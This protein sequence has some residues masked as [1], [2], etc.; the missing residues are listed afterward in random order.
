MTNPPERRTQADRVYHSIRDAILR[1]EIAE[2]ET[3]NHVA[4]AKKF[5]VSRIPVREALQ[6]L[7]AE[8][9]LVFEAYRGHR[10][11]SLGPE[12]L[13]ELIEIRILLE[14]RALRKHG[15][16]LPR[17]ELDDLLRLNEGLANQEDPELW[18]RSDWELHRRLSGGDT[19]IAELVGD[20]RRRI[21][22]YLDAASRMEDRHASAVAEHRA[23]L[24][25]L[26]RGDAR[27]A[28]KEL[29]QHIRHTGRALAALLR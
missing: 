22:R 29:R 3:L 14:C 25:A 12:E 13:E 20:V 1:G 5:G 15:V 23:I 16:R 2:G 11:A 27:E 10:V 9:L 26:V 24:E 19:P 4:L 7:Q 8:R 17:S 6:R 21:H 28:E 18:L